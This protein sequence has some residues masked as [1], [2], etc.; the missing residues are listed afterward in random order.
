MPMGTSTGISSTNG[1]SPIPGAVELERLALVRPFAPNGVALS[2][3][4]EAADP[5]RELQL[6]SLLRDV[7]DA[8]KES[9]APRRLVIDLSQVSGLLDEA[10]GPLVS[11]LV[12]FRGRDGVTITG[13]SPNIQKIF[14]Q[15]GLHSFFSS[16]ELVQLAPPGQVEKDLLDELITTIDIK[17]AQGELRNESCASAPKREPGYNGN[18]VVYRLAGDTAILQVNA[19]VIRIAEQSKLSSDLKSV[20]S[21]IVDSEPD[22]R[23]LLFDL[24]GLEFIGADTIATFINLR[25]GGHRGAGPEFALSSPSVAI[26]EKLR[27]AR[28]DKYIRVFETA[29]DAFHQPWYS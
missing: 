11:M 23:R 12:C 20:I 1:P 16:N 19:D 6:A 14:R 3:K 17:R 28:L 24:S 13:A 4:P 22:C 7:S 10:R 29:G 26:A 18:L 2:L 5:S 8:L 21:D 15:L 27:I 25:Q 9:S